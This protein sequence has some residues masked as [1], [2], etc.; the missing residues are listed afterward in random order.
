MADRIGQ[1]MA[2]LRRAR[3]MT[4][5]DLA[6]ES[7]V[8]LAMV[9]SVERGVRMPSPPLLEALASALSVDPSRL[10]PVYTGTHRRVHTVLPL[11]S[12]AI[13]GYDIPLD[14]PAR[15]LSEIQ[16]I[17][18]QAMAW[19]LAAQYGHIASAAP[20]L[21]AD[22]LGHLH[23]AAGR[24]HAETARLVVDAARAADA[25][26]YKFGAHDLSARL[27]DMM[28]WAADRTGDSD[29]IATAAYVRA[30]TFLAAEAHRAGQAALERT[31]DSITGRG[32]QQ[33]TA[34]RGALF[35]RTAVLA[36][37]AANADAAYTHL[38]E[39]GRLADGLREDVY[40]GTAF[41]PSSVRIH[42]VAVAVSLGREHI[43]HAL[44]VAR[45]W[46]PGQEIPAERR[47]GFYVELGRAQ[48][49]AGR[50]DDAFESLRVARRLAPQHVREHPW[51]RAD[52]AT[53]R[54]IK[55][56]DAESLSAFAEWIG[57]I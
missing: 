12:A 24:E 6:R 29:V 52:I 1:S 15:P 55:R 26:A 42:E 34:V 23:A 41:G 50:P 9:K 7:H 3:R 51:A 19:R 8:S 16:D 49:W 40:L 56:A 46:K 27:V 38:R 39:A 53:I 30:E 36:A 48:L 35:M 22:A 31:L 17:T 10:D 4:Q 2:A 54:R 5:Q 57:A 37:R 25:V 45:D 14:P 28:R 33:A 44:D 11:I 32:S 21:L 20:G 43:A 18:G 47:S 13:A